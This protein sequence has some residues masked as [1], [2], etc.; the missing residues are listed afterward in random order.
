MSEGNLEIREK[1]DQWYVGFF[2]DETKHNS[3]LNATTVFDSDS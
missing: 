3:G 1:K 2:I